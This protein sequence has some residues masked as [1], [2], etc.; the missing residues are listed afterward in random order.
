MAAITL[1]HLNGSGASGAS[2]SATT[3][4]ITPTAGRFYTVFCRGR[5]GSG[6]VNQPTITGWGLTWN[7][8]VGVRPSG[9]QINGAWLFYAVGSPTPGTL[10]IDFAGQSIST[11]AWTVDEWANVDN[12]S[13]GIVQTTTADTG[14]SSSVS[15]SLSAL[16]SSNNV[17]IGFGD[18]YNQISTMTLGSGYS[19][20]DNRGFDGD[21]SWATEYK[22]NTTTVDMSASQSK[23]W[24]GLAAELKFKDNS[25]TGG[26]FL[27]NFV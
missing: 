19:A 23:A 21:D 5:A 24:I 17:A 7:M 4:S 13:N 1:N 10:T 6:T 27:L 3:A 26:S 8:K 11:I 16:G 2:G 25:A 22:L 20:I 9:S 18:Q 14:A 12:S 15:M